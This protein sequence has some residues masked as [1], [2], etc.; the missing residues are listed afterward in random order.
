MPALVPF[1][2]TLV[3]AAA[4]HAGGDGYTVGRG[5]TLSGIA[6]RTGV[7][8]AELARANAITDPNLILAGQ[9]LDVPQPAA[10]AQPSTYTARAGDTL[11]AIAAGLGV[12]SAE[13]A[14]ANGITDPNR[15]LVGQVLDVPGGASTRQISAYSRLGTW[16]HVYD[17]V[18]AFGGRTGVPQL[19]PTSVAALAAAGIRT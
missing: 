15:I 14:R 18:P 17:Y 13:L 10:P 1:V 12:S 5:D 11:T 2:T 7:S 9:V 8:S 6:E 16:G 19:T 4:L 3:F